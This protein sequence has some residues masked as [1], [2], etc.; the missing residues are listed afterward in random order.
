MTLTTA[1]GL[2]LVLATG[3]ALAESPPAGAPLP[4]PPGP[5]AL[6]DGPQVD[7][8]FEEYDLDNG[9][10]VILAEDHSVPFVQVNVWYRVGS[11]DEVE[12]RTGFAHLFEH[13]MFQGSANMNDDYFVPL[14]RIGAQV[15][16][17]TNFDRTNYFEGVPS[18]QLPLALW[19][20]SDRMGWLLP[21][22]TQEKLDNQKEV[23]RN[24]RRQR[25]ENTPYGEVWVWLMES[26]FPQ[27][28]PYHVPTIGRHED[29][30][31]ATMDD[32]TAFFQTWY[33][34]NN[35]SLV[36]SGD[37]DPAEAK[38]LVDRYFS[39]IP[40]GPQP[41]P[42]L[43]YDLPDDWLADGLVVEKTDDVPHA[44]V[45][46]AWISPALYDDGDADLDILSSVLSDGKESRLY[47]H[48]V[49]E[50]QIARDVEAYQVSSIVQGAYMIEATAAAGHT[51][52]ELVEEIDTVLAK[53]RAEGPT[54]Q[55]VAVAKTNWQVR[56]FQGIQTIGRKAD[57]LQA[58]YTWKGD[59][60][61]IDDDLQRYLD[62]SADD[63]K[64][65]VQTWLDPDRRV[66]LHVR[67][68]GGDK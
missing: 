63:V 41:E 14:Q 61:F 37:F 50:L 25:Y 15:N 32:V 38:M 58:Y 30:E 54:K 44:K 43:S 28:H 11:K 35:A 34:P 5:A 51:T 23:V 1:L 12:G 2:G 10:H 40:A 68:E 9:L 36:I 48:L 46:I 4:E 60:G 33:L 65:A 29:L 64:N 67:P 56:F 39:E 66:V 8:P 49:H 59:P 16:G 13:L 57:L 45:W 47:S 19:L 53:L 22:L 62:V 3:P 24:E 20:E 21:A 7:I 52:E 55:E 18:E 27:D 17:T 26:L 31:A 42:T 6:P